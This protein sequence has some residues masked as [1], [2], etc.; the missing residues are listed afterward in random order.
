[1]I[2]E[3]GY[4]FSCRITLQA[5]DL[6]SAALIPTSAAKLNKVILVTEVLPFRR[7]GFGENCFTRV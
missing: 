6:I 2:L 4:I 5:S 7:K 3:A 1:M